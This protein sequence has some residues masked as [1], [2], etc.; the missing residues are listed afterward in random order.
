MANPEI[1]N[2]VPR[3]PVQA[4][5]DEIVA[6]LTRARTLSQKMQNSLHEVSR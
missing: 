6:E 5:A 3:D 4:L 2:Y 1:D